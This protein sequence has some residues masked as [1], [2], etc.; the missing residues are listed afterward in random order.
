VGKL[1]LTFTNKVQD[2]GQIVKDIKDKFEFFGDRLDPGG[3]DY[4]I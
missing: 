3:N 1:V 2:K 4:P